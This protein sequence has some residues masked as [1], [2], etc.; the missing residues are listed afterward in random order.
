M[1]R[2]FRPD[3]MAL[4]V[5]FIYAIAITFVGIFLIYP[6]IDLVASSVASVF[7][8]TKPLPDGFFLY[9]LRVTGN[10][11]LLAI[12]TTLASLVI[13]LPLALLVTK[14]RVRGA[15]FW[16]GLL[17]I[18]LITPAFISSFSVII[19]LG[20]TGVLT[21]ALR[22]IGIQ[23]PSIY[24]LL[25]LVITQTLHTIPYSLLIL[26]AGLKTVPRHLEEAAQSM[27]AGI[28]KTLFSVVIPSIHPHMLMACVMVFL[29]SIGD[30]GGPLIIGGR[31][32]VISMEIYSNFISYMGDER[33]PLIFSAWLILLSCV[34]M[35][36]VNKLMRLTNVKSKFR[37][38]IMEYDNRKIRIA[39]TIFIAAVGLL[40]MLPYIAIIVQSFAQ[41]WNNTWLP[42][43]YT[44]LHYVKVAGSGDAI[45]KTLILLG[46]V[47]PITVL[48]GIVFGQMY[49]TRPRLRW[50]SYITLL[51]FILPGVVIG[52]SLIKAYSTLTVFGISLSGSAVLLV[53]AISIRRLPVV[54]KPIEAG[55]AKI[56][57]GQEEA[58]VS[59]GAGEIKAFVS[60]I[61][62][63]IRI[64]VYSAIVIGLVK[65]VTEL[66]SSL[67]IYPPGWQN[68]SLY[69]AY[70]VAE[71]FIS[72]ASAMAVLMIVLVGVGTAVSNYLSAK[73]N[74]KY[75]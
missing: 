4:G 19:L 27:G 15:G 14:F 38:G 40:L 56:D 5:K 75:V 65:V 58:A 10:T 11:F 60:V 6:I 48:L 55:F 71:G 41:R 53:A 74:K 20:N 32:K 64:S 33:I 68:M 37:V 2:L 46:T 29:T 13:A 39:G 26:I 45:L 62:P 67:I 30:I 24:G 18:P 44:L 47:T 59:L 57:P 54:L 28:W 12:L 1:V 21:K 43:G 42:V 70:Y 61:F 51:P 22:L 17:T 36:G 9:I 23:F 69:V 31:Y 52:V 49:K 34:L 73:E 72:Q 66:A 63:Q 25:G 3:E 16:I 8:T 50:L 35:V 7:S